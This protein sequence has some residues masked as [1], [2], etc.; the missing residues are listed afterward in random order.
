MLMPRSFD[1]NRVRLAGLVAVL[2]VL[3]LLTAGQVRGRYD[4][5]DKDKTKDK[6]KD[7]N[8]KVAKFRV[9]LPDEEEVGVLIDGKWASEDG[10]LERVLEAPDLPKGKKEHDVTAVWLPN[11]Y[12]MFLRTRKVAPK[13]GDTVDVDLR[14]PDPKNPDR[15]EIRF[16][17]TPDDVVDRMCKLGKIGK[18]DV[19][20]DLGCGDGRMVARAVAKHG[21]RR[22]VGIDLDPERVK[23]S[24]ETAKKYKVEDKLEFRQGDVLDVKDLKDASVILIY[25]GEDVNLRLMPIFKR[26][27]KEGSRIVSHEFGFRDKW[28]PDKTEKF[29]AEDGEDYR[30]HLWTIKKDDK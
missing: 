29:T 27:L 13:A 12:T 11:N 1:M 24:K 16:V 15:I 6:E 5:K 10:G 8:G 30:I 2:A 17:P 28:T 9:F 7:K 3:T 20:Y 4:D 22:G 14:K 18:D 21:A 19:V 23:D 25:M 26:T